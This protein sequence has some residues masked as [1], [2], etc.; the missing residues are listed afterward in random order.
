MI[1]GIGIRRAWQSRWL[2]RIAFVV[3][4]PPLVYGFL[5][6]AFEQMLSGSGG[7]FSPSDVRNLL[8]I[9]LPREAGTAISVAMDSVRM[10]SATDWGADGLLTV[11]RPI[12]WKAVLLQLQRSQTVGLVIVVGL[13]APPLISQDVRSRAFLL[14]FSRPLTRLQYIWGKFATVA[15]FLLLVCTLPQLMLYTFAVLL[16]P[17]I[18]VVAHTWDLPVRVLLSSA[19][20]IFPATLLALMLSSLTNETR[21]ATFGWFTIWIFGLVA[22]LAMLSLYRETSSP[23]IRFCFLFLLFS[24]LSTWIM[25]YSANVRDLLEAAGLSPEAMNL[26]GTVNSQMGVPALQSLTPYAES[27]FAFAVGL[28]VVCYMLIFRRV[29]APLQA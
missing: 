19:T 6:F 7:M 10:A 23:V 26:A 12:F 9:L 14:Y 16:S 20:V 25:D 24:D 15:S 11:V 4:A 27:Q 3:W 5:V 29:S 21:F 13:V 17:D 28:S 8:E 22:S 18:S 1:A 2:R